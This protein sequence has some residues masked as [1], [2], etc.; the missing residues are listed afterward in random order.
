MNLRPLLIAGPP[1]IL[2]ALLVAGA[3]SGCGKLGQLEKPS[4]LNGSGHST[5]RQAD[6]AARQAQDPTHPVDTVDPRDRNTDPAPP[7]AAPIQGTGPDPFAAGPPGAF[8][9][10]FTNPR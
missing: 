7:R 1:R 6:E 3:L 10:P 9:N 2:L 8:G 4:A 5:T